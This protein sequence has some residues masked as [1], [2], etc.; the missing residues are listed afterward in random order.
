MKKVVGYGLYCV[1]GVLFIPNGIVA[2]LATGVTALIE[3]PLVK[4]GACRQYRGGPLYEYVGMYTMMPT[5]VV[6]SSGHKL[7]HGT[8]LQ[9]VFSQG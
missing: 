9:L 6:V 7:I 3:L 4:S 1:G 8:P 2:L 5:I